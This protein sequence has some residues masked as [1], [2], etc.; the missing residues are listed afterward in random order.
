MRWIGLHRLK[1]VP[2]A[3][4]CV[5]AN[6]QEDERR[7]GLTHTVER[8]RTVLAQH[9]VRALVGEHYLKEVGDR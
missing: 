5:Q 8:C 4:R 7:Q 1:D 2:A 6:V 9:D 3:L